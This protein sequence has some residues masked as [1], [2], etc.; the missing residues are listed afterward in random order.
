MGQ[1]NGREW[2][3]EMFSAMAFCGEWGVEYGV[4]QMAMEIWRFRKGCGMAL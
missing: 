2:G 1:G 3:N 4:W